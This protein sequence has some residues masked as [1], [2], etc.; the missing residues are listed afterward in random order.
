MADDQT[1]TVEQLQA[2]VRRL[3][4]RCA[5][6]EA[7]NAAL[8]GRETALTDDVARFQ[9]ALAE[10][11]EQQTAT[12]EIL[13]VIATSPADAQP[14]ID[15][16]V[17]T[18]MRL[19]H[20]TTSVLCIREGDHLRN[21]AVGSADG[22]GPSILGNVRPLTGR[23]PSVCAFLERRTIHIPDA[24]DPS[25]IDEYPDSGALGPW[26]RV[27]APL[28]GNHEA[29]G[30]LDVARDR[31]KPFSGREIALLETFADQA[32]IAIEN[33]RLF[34]E[35]E[36]RNH[37]LTETLEQQTATA[38]ILRAIATSPADAQPVLDAVVQSAMHLM[39]CTTAVVRIREGDHL[40]NAAIC[41]EVPQG[42]RLQV[43]RPLTGRLPSVR[44]FFERRTIHVPDGL[45]PAFV[46]EYPDA[47]PL[48]P[49]ARVVVP[50]IRDND[51]IGTLEVFRTRDEP[52]SDREIA[53]LET[54]ADQAVIA[55]ENARLF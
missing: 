38:E 20:S 12:A 6:A 16:V 2:E 50:L 14:V 19:T 35:L 52:F 53:L 41:D 11:H 42:P 10:A 7:E 25:F 18:A 51:A 49:V 1:T 5:A 39:H 29:L 36:Q 46:A 55:I 48:L 3:Q 54:F 24:L 44:A 31:E 22:R 45:A 8:S 23:I 32:V 27:V 28:I 13:R 40:R 33:A 17:Q 47:S 21:A 37:D 43:V 15:A 34:E 30:T 4:E 9:A 26:T